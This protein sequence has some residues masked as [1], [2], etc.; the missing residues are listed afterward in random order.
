MDSETQYK[1]D[2]L[3]AIAISR[4]YSDRLEHRISRDSHWIEINAWTLNQV[5]E[6]HQ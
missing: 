5:Q 6:K 4:E 1:Y 2:A 3:K